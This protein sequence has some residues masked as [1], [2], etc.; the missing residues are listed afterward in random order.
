MAHR[1]RDW[2]GRERERIKRRVLSTLSAQ[3]ADT[4]HKHVFN[5][6]TA[7]SSLTPNT[8]PPS[9]LL[10]SQQ[11]AGPSEDRRSHRVKQRWQTSRASLLDT[12]HASGSAE[13]TSC[14]LLI[15]AVARRPLPF[16]GLSKRSSF[17]AMV[18]FPST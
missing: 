18:G 9:S 13:Y 10:L 5:L 14:P 15:P 1:V 4:S 7:R 11:D 3:T 6:H 17:A 8:K 12:Q 2:Q 16:P